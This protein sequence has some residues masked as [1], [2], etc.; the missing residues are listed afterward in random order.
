MC[1]I[2]DYRRFAVLLL[3]LLL[4]L[5]G[6]SIAEPAASESGLEPDLEQIIT[7]Q[8]AADREAA[9]AQKRIDVAAAAARGLAAQ[10]LAIL[11]ERD[12]LRGLND[13]LE[14]RVAAEAGMI[15]SAAV[16]IG[17]A[18]VARGDLLP[19]MT[20]MVATLRELTALDLPFRSAER[21]NRVA[22]L[23][24]ALEAPDR[25]EAELLRLILDA[26]AE[27]LAYGSEVFA[28]TADL[29]IDGVSRSVELLH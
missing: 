12:S 5:P 28:E 8:M 15:R 16:R 19:L 21:A 2:S 4:V 17:E 9:A 10:Y 11:A 3:T 6:A 7:E 24:A 22:E 23:Q 29:E 14:Q 25:S 26:Y 13:R 1:R 20:S 18:R 27:E